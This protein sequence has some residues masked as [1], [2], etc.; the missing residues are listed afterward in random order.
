MSNRLLKKGVQRGLP[1]VAS[2]Q[3]SL[4]RAVRAVASVTT[5][6]TAAVS[7]RIMVGCSLVTAASADV[8]DRNW[9]RY[10][11]ASSSAPIVLQ[12]DAKSAEAATLLRELARF[13]ALVDKYIAPF[14]Q[15]AGE[16]AP[17]LIGQRVGA[18]GSDELRLLALTRRRDF[19]RLFNPTHFAGFTLP[20]LQHTTLVVG[21]MG[22][23]DGLRENLL[24]E[25]VHF[26]LRRDVPGGLPLWFEEGLA[27]YLAMVKF[28]PRPKQS[29]VELTPKRRVELGHWIGLD[30]RPEQFIRRYSNATGAKP[31]RLTDLIERRNLEGL[32]RSSVRQFY[33]TS[34]ALVRHLYANPE[35]DRLALA[36]LLVLDSSSFPKGINLDLRVAARAIGK[37]YETTSGATER[38]ALRVPKDAAVSV[39]KLTPSE[40]RYA[41]ADAAL[42]MNPPAA[43]RLFEKLTTSQP[44]QT[45]AWLGASKALRLQ[46]DSERAESRLAVAQKLAPGSA[47]VLLEQAAIHTSGCLFK[48]A[49]S[50]PA[51][52]LTAMLDLR[53][54]LDQNPNNY[55][56][57]YRLGIAHL[58]MG[59]P[60]EAQGYLQVAWQRVPWSPQA[61]FFLGE[62]LRLV[63]DTR[64]RWYL[65]NAHR[66]ASSAYYQ[67]VSAAALRLLPD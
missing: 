39:A 62:S 2:V 40:V 9:Q 20:T 35:L 60:G 25:Y 59:Q 51:A 61:N 1:E 12:T 27:S 63:G 57:I 7:L 23:R 46:D 64:A 56:A 53:D 34:H 52:W 50:C 4:L 32:A 36:K 21:P 58:Y 41:L 11:L 65:N 66:W 54:A 37:H 30:E 13:D 14:A 29:A 26:R 38:F 10:E 19:S 47:A 43:T 44:Q 3:R 55:E 28:A 49:P 5:A 31:M 24:H 16:I 67:K 8:A 33:L 45:L 6:G 18:A 48:P 42:I 17:E 15:L 22:G